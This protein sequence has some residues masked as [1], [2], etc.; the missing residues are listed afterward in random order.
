[1]MLTVMLVAFVVLLVASVPI[2]VA[3]GAATFLAIAVGGGYTPMVVIQRFYSGND[4]FVLL[5]IPLYIRAGS[6]M[7]TGGIS[8]RLVKLALVMVGH[9]RGGLGMVVVVAEY[10]FSGLSGSVVADVSA[11]GSLL[12]P[13][14]IKGGYKP[15]DSVSIV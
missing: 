11:V 12:V 5:A 7:E 13:A 1:M 2:A 10:L 8:A 9:V 4:S 14:M 15:A 6:L 3:M